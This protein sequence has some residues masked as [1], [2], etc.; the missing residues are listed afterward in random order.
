MSGGGS[1]SGALGFGLWSLGNL[2][3][4]SDSYRSVYLMLGWC[5][6]FWEKLLP[7][8]LDCTDVV[9]SV[10][11]HQEQIEEARRLHHQDLKASVA[12]HNHEI[13]VGQKMHKQEVRLACKLHDRE[14][15][16][17]LAMHNIALQVELLHAS[18]ENIRD[19]AEQFISK[20]STFLLVETLL[21]GSL[22]TVI[23]EAE[24]PP[25]TQQEMSW[26][27]TLYALTSGISFM[28]L[29][30]AV[31]LTYAT[32]E[33][34]LKLRRHALGGAFKAFK[35]HREHWTQSITKLRDFYFRLESEREHL[36]D[37]FDEDI[38]T[39]KTMVHHSSVAFALGVLTLACRLLPH[40]FLHSSSLPFS[41]TRFRHET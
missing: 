24:L 14:K 9:K 13:D 25:N 4:F 10:R 8:V 7:N 37:A 35:E 22:F 41:F 6:L 34:V 11:H 31:Y 2:G 5:Q 23:I 3:G 36:H 33:R 16:M 39:T 32:Q 38:Q 1:G 30:A 20:I 27:V 15:E 17:A 26:L 28:T 21:L 18:C 40:S 12:L 19:T 29:S